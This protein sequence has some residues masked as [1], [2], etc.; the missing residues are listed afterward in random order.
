MRGAIC[1]RNFSNGSCKVGT[2]FS[3]HKKYNSKRIP[4]S[5]ARQRYKSTVLQ[6]VVTAINSGLGGTPAKVRKEIKE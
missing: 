1:R 3:P 4:F 5:S 6:R 2:V